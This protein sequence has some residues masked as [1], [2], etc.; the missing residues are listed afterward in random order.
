MENKCNT[1]A[2]PMENPVMEAIL[3]RRS[4]RKFKEEPV[5]KECL[6]ALA[7]A[8]IYAPSGRG[9]Q[10]WQITV[11]DRRD[12]I[13]RLAKAIEEV[14]DRPGYDMYRP[15]AIIIPSN[16]RNSIYGKEDDACALENIF[17]AAHSMGI[18]SVWINQ[19]QNVCDDARIRAVLDQMK[20][21]ADHVVYGLAALGYSAKETETDVV[22]TGKI[23][24]VE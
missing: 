7:Q 24:F 4:V 16:E 9:L 5:P 19:L 11:V 2:Q 23:V 1:Q 3:T 22:K 8:A 13:D 14:L 12:L 18:G 15:A 17:L 10:T 6:A 21:P 20:I